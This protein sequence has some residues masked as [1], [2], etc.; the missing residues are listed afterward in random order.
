[1]Q[2]GVWGA[3]QAP[4]RW[5]GMQKTPVAPAQSSAAA[6]AQHTATAGGCGKRQR[7]AIVAG[8]RGG[9]FPQAAGF[10]GTSAAH[11][12]GP[13]AVHNVSHAL[14]AEHGAA[15]QVGTPRH[16]C[17]LHLLQGDARQVDGQGPAERPGHKLSRAGWAAQHPLCTSCCSCRQQ[18]AVQSNTSRQAGEAKRV[19]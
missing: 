8:S 7:Q 6:A 19:P 17:C 10:L 9:R 14:D 18:H 2:G 16:R 4:V 12:R 11:L 1:M 3:Q 5:L 15:K 13:L